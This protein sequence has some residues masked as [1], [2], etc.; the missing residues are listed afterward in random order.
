M[1]I[2]TGVCGGDGIGAGG[3]RRRIGR[4]YYSG[5]DEG[6]IMWKEVEDD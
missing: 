6:G 4:C 5:G 3:D 2:M 1:G